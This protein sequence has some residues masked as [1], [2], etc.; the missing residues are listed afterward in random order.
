[1]LRVARRM[2]GDEHAAEDAVQEGLARAFAG[3]A[4]FRGASRPFTWLCGVLL[5][6]CRREQRRRSLRR[7]LS[8]ERVV[9]SDG[10]QPA[11]GPAPDAQVEGDERRAALER[12]LAKLPPKQRAALVLVS[13]EGLPVEE[14]AAALSCS[15]AAVWKSLSRGRAALREELHG[16]L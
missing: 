8:L 7:W 15:P 4:S 12:A 6:V 3:R 13:L 1:L 9:E 16:R 14:A 2:L 10:P 5:N 11:G